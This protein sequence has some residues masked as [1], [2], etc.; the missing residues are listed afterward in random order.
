[1]SQDTPKPTTN[2]DDYPKRIP[3]D[4]VRPLPVG[5][6]PHGPDGG[7]P[8]QPQPERTDLHEQQSDEGPG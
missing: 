8:L 3:L 7:K 1:M 6:V 2:G 4:E 5:P